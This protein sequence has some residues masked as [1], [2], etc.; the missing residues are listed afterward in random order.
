MAGSARFTALLD[1]CVLFPPA[2]ADAL[3]SLHAEGLYSAKW[4]D[5]IDCEWMSAAV[6]TYPQ[7]QGKLDKRRDTMRA[8]VPDWEVTEASYSSLL[9][10]LDLSDKNDIHVLAAAIAGHADCI[11]TANLKH[12]PDHILSGHGLEAIHPDDFIVYQLD[13]ESL[14]A[15]RA[16]KKM[17]TRK[18]K[19]PLDAEAFIG[20]LER[21][22]LVT[23]AQRLRD[24]SELI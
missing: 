21:N 20:V 14:A 7:L 15:L 17:R 12:F 22:G 4:S 16:F 23:T 1:A 8:A 10:D 9:P 19:P 5:R 2:V 11:V 3:M 24:A 13:L 18:T 6:R